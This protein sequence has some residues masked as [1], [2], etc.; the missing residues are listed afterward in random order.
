MK[1]V[2]V[3]NINVM[4]LVQAQKAILKLIGAI[5]AVLCNQLGIVVNWSQTAL[6]AMSEIPLR[7][8]HVFC[9]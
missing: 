8:R 1:V 9:V 3:P 5:L 2:R 7:T 4:I 6:Q